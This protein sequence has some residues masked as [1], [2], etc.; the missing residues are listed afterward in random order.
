MATPRKTIDVFAG[1]NPALGAAVLRSFAEGYSSVDQE[2]ALL[3]LMW[4]VLPQILSKRIGDTM[5]GTNVRT[6]LLNWIARNPEVSIGLAN[7]VQAT[8]PFTRDSIAFGIRYGLLKFSD[9]RVLASDE[10]LRRQIRFPA[11]DVRGQ[12][13]TRASRLGTWMAHMPNP[14]SIF[15][16][17]GLSL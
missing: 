1:T 9:G 13:L 15:Y 3:P 6:G 17:F 4:L 11:S 2:G 12:A 5:R 8:A 7:R 10:G 16:S 14:H